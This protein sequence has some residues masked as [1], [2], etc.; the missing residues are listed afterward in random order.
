MK[1][2]S[3]IAGSRSDGI[4]AL[5][6]TV[7]LYLGLGA[8]FLAGCI[9]APGFLTVPNQRDVLRSTADKGLIS[10]GMTFVILTAGIDL[11]VGRLV[12][13]T[14]TVAA[15]L[16]MERSWNLASQI[17]VPA[18]AAV[19]MFFVGR[20]VWSLAGLAGAPR[21]VRLVPSVLAG[22]AAAMGLAVWGASQVPRGFGVAGV[23]VA[24]PMVGML[25]GAFNGAVIAKG[26]L[27]PF[28]VT[29]AMMVSAYGLAKYIAG[30]G[31]QVH[32]VYFA[33]DQ[34]TPTFELL[35]HQIVIAGQK[36]IPV[37]ALFFLGAAL[38]AHVLL[39]SQRFGRQAYAV[40]GN[41]E[42]ARLSGINVDAVKVAVYAISGALAGVSG[43][44]FCAQYQQGWPDAG[45]AWELD[46]I[47]AVVIGGTSLMGGRG[48]ISGTFVGVLIFQ[49]LK[50]ILD[51]RGF[52]PETQLLLTGIIILLAVLLQ[53]VRFGR[54]RRGS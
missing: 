50:N 17:A 52:R 28:I 38:I 13:L 12:G 53:E 36:V 6:T 18:M 9:W 7:G 43:V 19:G 30:K 51:L 39:S 24:A 40:G 20:L 1:L 27:Q 2:L 11:S 10:L 22:L 21:G 14:S 45:S 41:E 32:A 48:G 4:R 3:R 15:M 44:L 54:W 26:R 8:I 47:A 33:P 42:S 46:A 34:A 5:L 31:G 25:L 49:Y 35:R 37:P 16:L 23:L 29:L